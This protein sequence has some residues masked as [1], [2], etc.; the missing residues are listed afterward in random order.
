MICVGGGGGGY[1]ATNDAER[2]GDGGDSRFSS[3][4]VAY[5]GKG[6]Q[7]LKGLFDLQYF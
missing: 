6:G 5:G 1:D 3:Y 4:L 2:A 7:L